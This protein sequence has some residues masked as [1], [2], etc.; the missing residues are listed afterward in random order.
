MSRNKY[1]TI[2]PSTSQYGS[3]KEVVIYAWSKYE[4]SSV[5]AG[6]NK[7]TYIEEFDSVELAL[8][9]FPNAI[10]LEGIAETG[11]TFGHLPDTPDNDYISE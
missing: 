10:V 3:G 5:L 1:H 11:N 7:K 6:Q 9:S 8:K 2:E 4:N